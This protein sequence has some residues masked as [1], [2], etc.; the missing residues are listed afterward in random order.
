P[1]FWYFVT[2]ELM[3]Q[4]ARMYLQGITASPSSTLGTIAGFLPSP[5]SDV[6]RV[7]MR[8]RLIWTSMANDMSVIVFIIGMTIA[9]THMFS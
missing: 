8:Y 1:M 4:S 5:F 6:V 7:F 9:L 2:M 3:L